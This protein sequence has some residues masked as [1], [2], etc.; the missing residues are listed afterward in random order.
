MHENMIGGAALTNWLAI[1]GV[2]SLMYWAWRVIAAFRHRGSGGQKAAAA[3]SAA[4]APVLAPTQTEQLAPPN[5]DI[6]VIAAAVYAML[7]THRI[8]HLEAIPSGKAWEIEGRWAQQ[9][10]HTPR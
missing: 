4:N 3:P 1:L 2:I 9:T 8:V 10:S 6:A 5:E 7:G